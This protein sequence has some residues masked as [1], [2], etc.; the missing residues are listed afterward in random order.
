M[1][2]GRDQFQQR[3]DGDAQQW[4]IPFYSLVYG[5]ENQWVIPREVKKGDRL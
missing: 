4:V 2:E 5:N 3:D 1:Q